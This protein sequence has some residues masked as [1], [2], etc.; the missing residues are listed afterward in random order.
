ML[1][2]AI[3]PLNYSLYPTIR[4]QYYSQ[5][6]NTIVESGASASTEYIYRIWNASDFPN[7]F[8]TFDYD[9]SSWN[10]GAAPFGDDDLNGNEPNTIWQTS[11]DNYTYIAARHLFNY[12]GDQNFVK[13]A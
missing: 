11:D 9:D 10:T 6:T 4:S 3:T 12:D 13:Y 8:Y 1:Q 2:Q 7:D 5:T